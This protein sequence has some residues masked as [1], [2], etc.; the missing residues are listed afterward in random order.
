MRQRR[1]REVFFTM[2]QVHKIPLSKIAEDFKLEIIV[3]PEN[4]DQIQVMSPEVNRPG[5]ALAGFYE[6]FEPERI[7]LVGKA[8]NSYLESLEPS[9]RRLMLQKFVDAR[10]VAIIYKSWQA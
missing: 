2:K 9:T 4:F 5:L 1:R 7:Q 8:E 10:P 6:I 3:R